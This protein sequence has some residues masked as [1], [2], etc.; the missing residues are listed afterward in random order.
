M[1]KFDFEVIIFGYG[2]GGLLINWFLD[3]G[4]FEVLKNDILDKC[5]DGVILNFSGFMAF[6]IDSFV[7]FFIFFLG[8][9][10]GELVVNGIVNDFVMCGVL[11]EYLFLSFILEEGLLV[12]QFWEVLVGVKVVCELVGV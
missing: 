5:Y 10:I 1:F 9:N 8:G 11:F 7:I 12:K 2:S 4:V 6:I 3:S